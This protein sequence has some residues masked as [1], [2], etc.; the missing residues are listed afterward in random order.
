MTNV[1][2]DGLGSQTSLTMFVPQRTLIVFNVYVRNI[3]IMTLI[4]DGQILTLLAFR[5]LALFV[6]FCLVA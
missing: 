2:F 4:L 5:N 6:E 1:K 3:K